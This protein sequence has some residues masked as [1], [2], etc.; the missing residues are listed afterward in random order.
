VCS[1]DLHDL[2]LNIGILLC[3][4]DY[5]NVEQIVDDISFTRTILHAAPLTSPAIYDR[6]ILLTKRGL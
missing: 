5:E 6:D 4:S 3:S 2:Q 1:S